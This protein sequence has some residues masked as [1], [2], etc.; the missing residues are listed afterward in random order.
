MVKGEGER[1][2]GVVFEFDPVRDREGIFIC[3][4]RC[5]CWMFIV[6][7]IFFFMIVVIFLLLLLLLWM[8]GVGWDGW[9]GW[10]KGSISQIPRVQSLTIPIH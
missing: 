2:L 6:I 5:C 4:V 9:C 1:D 7:F 3:N 10:A 8:G